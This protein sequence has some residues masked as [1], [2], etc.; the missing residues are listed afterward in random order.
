[1]KQVLFLIV[2][3]LECFAVPKNI[4]LMIG[5]GMGAEHIRAAQF[6]L[7]GKDSCILETF[8][9]RTWMSTFSGD[10][11]YSP[12]SA[13]ADALYVRYK[14]TDSA[15][16]ATALSTGVKTYDAAIGVDMVGTPLQT[17]S[18]AASLAG[19]ATGVVTTVPFSHATPA[20]MVAHQLSRN[21]FAQI[22]TEMIFFSHLDVI[23]GGGHPG[24]DPDGNPVSSELWNYEYSGGK[25]TWNTL[26]AGTAN[27][28]D[29][30][31]WTL[32]QSRGAID[33]IAT[34][35]RKAPGNLIGV[36]PVFE[37]LQQRR[38]SSIPGGPALEPMPGTSPLTSTVPTLSS[39]TL[40]AFRSLDQNPQGFYLMVEGGA[41]DWAS[42][43]NQSSRM[44]EETIDF[45]QAV[46]TVVTWIETHGGWEENLLIITADHETGYLSSPTAG[47]TPIINQGKGVMPD[48]RWFAAAH[49]NSLVRLFAKGKY[50]EE[51]LH[52]IQGIDP[53]RGEYTDNALIGQF[54]H[55]LLAS[56]WMIASA[57]KP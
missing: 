29:G 2:F 16:S 3:A 45:F 7:N 1:M 12:D 24:F 36:M 13:A 34:G 49:T 25:E 9:V 54:V 8:P 21:S 15:A 11:N 4:I 20:G 46:E 14:P 35:K 6:Y 50:S 10:G 5:D 31:S 55:R 23:L 27:N 53:M 32:V 56:R 17:I 44:I 51:I 33:S 48:M 22:A 18:E 37:T 47:G 26:V 39:M 57:G 41:I 40:A 28:L 19:K 52:L 30:A 43:K 42:H 38:T